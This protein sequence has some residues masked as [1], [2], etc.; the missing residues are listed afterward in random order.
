[1]LR[2]RNP[3]DLKSVAKAKEKANKYVTSDETNKMVK[4]AILRELNSHLL[5]VRAQAI[6]GKP[7]KEGKEGHKKLAVDTIRG[8]PYRDQSVRKRSAHG[9]DE[10][11]LIQD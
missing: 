6:H 3:P 4:Q 8:N 2:K 5:S 1:M 9:R 11:K 7:H 10:G